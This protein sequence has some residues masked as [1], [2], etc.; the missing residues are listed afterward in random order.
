MPKPVADRSYDV[1]FAP[2]EGFQKKAKID[3]EGARTVLRL[4]SEF[5]KPQ[6]NL[7]DP[8]KYIDE[9]YHQRAMR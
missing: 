2:N 3:L 1:M 9:S 7:A 4:R 8:M 5:A 6:K